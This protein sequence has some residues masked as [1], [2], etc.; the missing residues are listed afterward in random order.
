[1]LT[2]SVLTFWEIV[3][4]W[5]TEKKQ[6][7][8]STIIRTMRAAATNFPN[9]KDKPASLIASPTILFNSQNE[10]KKYI[11]SYAASKELTAYERSQLVVHPEEL[12]GDPNLDKARA[13]LNSAHMP[14]QINEE[15]KHLLSLFSIV[16]ENFQQ[17]CTEIGEPL[18]KFWFP[19]EP[20][21][22]NTKTIPPASRTP[23]TTN[24]RNDA[25]KKVLLQA[26][27]KC[28]TTHTDIQEKEL[29]KFIWIY[30]ENLAATGKHPVI[31]EVKRKI[32]YWKRLNG[33]EEK[34]PIEAVRRRVTKIISM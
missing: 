18:P 10:R 21:T 1:M 19:T 32:V 4:K 6:E 27:E 24:K 13:F 7:R 3:E 25:L 28:Q 5:A 9:G 30:L 15:L 11:A 29:M 17:W 16:R 31:Q 22:M 34:T 33:T 8:I 2:P 26:V 14:P 20:T 23:P 12:F